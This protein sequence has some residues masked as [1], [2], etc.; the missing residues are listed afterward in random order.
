MPGLRHLFCCNG[1][2]CVLDLHH[3]SY[4]KCITFNTV[5]NK[6]SNEYTH[7]SLYLPLCTKDHILFQ[8][9]FSYFNDHHWNRL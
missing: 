4:E 2:I 9:T 8:S 5:F 1:D 7:F 6:Y 3:D